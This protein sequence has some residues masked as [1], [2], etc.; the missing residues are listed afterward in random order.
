MK[1]QTYFDDAAVFPLRFSAPASEPLQDSFART[2]SYLRL[3]ITEK[4]NFR[5]QY[6]L[7]NGYVA[8]PNTQPELSRAEIQRLVQGF[9]TLGLRKVRLTGGEP[10]LRKDLTDVIADIA[11]IPQIEKVVLSTNGYRLARDVRSWQMAGLNAV[12]I[13]IDS[14][15]SVRFA[16]LTGSDNLLQV[17]RGVEQ[18]VHTGLSQVKINAVLLAQTDAT[19]IL[20]FFDYVRH[21]PVTVRFIELMETAAQPAYFESH[22]QSADRLLQYL[23]QQG[24]QECIRTADAGPAR[25]FSHP[26]YAGRI[27]VIAPYSKGFCETC[28]RLRVTAQGELLTCLFATERHALR[29]WL[30]SET[31][32]SALSQRLRTLTAQKSATHQL[33]LRQSGLNTGFSAIGG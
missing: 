26:D 3:S 31:Q 28:N 32:Q 30:Q 1:L 23:M 14:L 7:P 13:S 16:R 5:C 33:Q 17:L 22:R 6:C 25:E 11:N 29:P 4:C 12:N 20:R 15:D 9:A 21:V 2:F 19:E 18:A 10:S 24:W 8:K 27:G